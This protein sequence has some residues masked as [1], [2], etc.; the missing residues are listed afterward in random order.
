MELREKK[1]KNL[2]PKERTGGDVG[3]IWDHTAV[4]PRTK[5]MVSL[6]QSRSRDQKASDRLVE[7]FADR[8]KHVPPELVTTDEH[9]TYK[10]S[11]T[12]TYGRGSRRR[13]PVPGMVYATVNKTRKHGRVVSVMTTLVLG[14]LAELA[15]ALNN[16]PC[17]SSINTAFVERNNGTAR[18][19]NARK[20]RKTYSI[21]K[22]I[23]EHEAMS[24]LMLT[25][26]NFCWPH[27]MIRV[28]TGDRTYIQRSPAVAAK[29]TDHIWSVEEM[30]TWQ[31]FTDA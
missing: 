2:T 30:L 1:D 16:S 6:V 21:S 19:F 14:T 31:A 23:E 25:H 20:Q 22:Q 18:H 12:K 28:R 10:N 8:T 27:R 11:L 7:D 13:K 26:Y 29:I 9:A 3:S 15:R 24:W 5:L 4:D 17:S